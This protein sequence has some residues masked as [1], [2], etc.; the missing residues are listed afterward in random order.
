MCE[1]CGLIYSR[2]A[3]VRQMA[4]ATGVACRRCGATLKA[5][6][7]HPH[8]GLRDPVKAVRVAAHGFERASSGWRF[9]D[10]DGGARGGWR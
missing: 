8:R 2:A 10:D 9:V 1:G 5:Q 7:E 6:G 4:L 3:I